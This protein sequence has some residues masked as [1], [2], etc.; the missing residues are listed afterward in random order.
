MLELYSKLDPIKNA[1]LM[2]V[3]KQDYNHIIEDINQSKSVVTLESSGFNKSSSEKIAHKLEKLI[4]RKDIV[5]VEINSSALLQKCDFDMAL[6]VIEIGKILDNPMSKSSNPLE[7]CAEQI[8]KIFNK[9]VTSKHLKVTTDNINTVLSVIS[10]D[11][12]HPV[13][14]ENKEM[15]SFAQKIAAGRDIKLHD[16]SRKI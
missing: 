8:S 2:N 16:N 13:Y 3:I 5:V 12:L 6:K 14:V 11:E 4:K 7:R 15:S 1:D 10:A 9:M